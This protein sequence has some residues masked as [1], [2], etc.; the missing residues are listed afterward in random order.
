MIDL[1]TK[2][3][4]RKLADSLWHITRD[5]RD[6]MHEPDEQGVEGAVI[7]HRFDNAFCLPDRAKTYSVSD[8]YDLTLVLSRERERLNVN[9]ADLVALARLAEVKHD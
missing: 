3:R 5:C 1:E 6:D 8:P 9:L 2:Q 4:L 7:G